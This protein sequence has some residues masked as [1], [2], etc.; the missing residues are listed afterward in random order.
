LTLG[1]RWKWVVSFTPRWP[2]IWTFN[3]FKVCGIGWPIFSCCDKSSQYGC[4]ISFFKV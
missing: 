4:E 2:S 3:N 1:T